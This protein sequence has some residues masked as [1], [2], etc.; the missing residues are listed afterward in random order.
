MTF[1]EPLQ[2]VEATAFVGVV[3]KGIEAILKVI[4]RK[5]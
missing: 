1:P 4:L 5:R 3:F 2:L